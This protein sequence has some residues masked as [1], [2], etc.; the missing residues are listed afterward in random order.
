MSGAK[1][2]LQFLSKN[3]KTISPLLILT[4]DYP[5]PDS[6]ASAY[7]LHYLVKSHYGINSKI[8]YGGIISRIE[9][10]YMV[11]WLKIPLRRLKTVDFRRY[12]HVAL[13][14]TQPD[15]DN[16][17][18]PKDMRA[19]IVIDQHSPATKPAA[20]LVIVEPKRD[21]TCEI[22]SQA[23]LS[24]KIDVPSTL[25]TALVYGILSDTLNLYRVRR[26]EIFQT[27]LSLLPYCNMEILIQLQNPPRMKNFYMALGQGIQYAA[28]YDRL[29]S[30]HLG[31]ID[32]PVLVAHIADFLLPY[33]GMSWSFCTGRYKG[34]LYLSLRAVNAN[35]LAYT[36]LHDVVI[37]PSSTGGH[38]SIA[39]G[40][41]EVGKN[42]SERAWKK[43]E[44]ALTQRL[45]KRLHLS[46][47]NKLYFPFRRY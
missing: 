27:Y 30:C 43:A 38:G 29:I 25:A 12:P 36:I 9:N 17:S 23:L 45:I 44:R 19:T 14:D 22:L 21:A 10:R 2:L 26:R 28:I 13:V 16:N 33:K 46:S 20:N 32:D 31:F 18:F 1:R 47:G 11:K 39:G 8:V 41:I 6:I 34:K 4:H 37:D 42:A 3:K 35:D 40:S 5:D 7:A 15:F 24:A